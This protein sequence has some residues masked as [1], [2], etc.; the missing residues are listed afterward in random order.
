K[1]GIPTLRVVSLA[2][3]L[4]SLSAVWL[5]AIT[6]TGKSNITFYIE[7]VAIVVY[8]VYAYVVLE[9]LQLSI[10]W[11]WAA[12]LIY[13]SFLGGLSYLY[14]KSGRWKHKVI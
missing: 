14:I 12:E 7:L 1:E 2:L 11:G 10:T 13:W 6:G 8:S 3:V 5:N 4:M 9:V